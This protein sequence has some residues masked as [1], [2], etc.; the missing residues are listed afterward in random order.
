MAFLTQS[1]RP[2]V[3]SEVILV[4]AAAIGFSTGFC[5]AIFLGMPTFLLIIAAAFLGAGLSVVS[6]AS[7]LSSISERPHFGGLLAGQFAGLFAIVL[8]IISALI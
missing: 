5:A 1:T 8:F 4:I 3:T 7:V 2:I 6:C